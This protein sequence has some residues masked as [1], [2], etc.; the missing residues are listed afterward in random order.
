MA[1]FNWNEASLD[2][3]WEQEHCF[4]ER[5]GPVARFTLN[6]PEK[7]NAY[8]MDM[9]KPSVPV[10]LL[11]ARR[12]DRQDPMADQWMLRGMITS[13]VHIKNGRAG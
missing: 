10:R 12:L 3:K 1:D 7:R 11:S 2:S 4:F 5:K 6:R 13:P 9:T 8:T